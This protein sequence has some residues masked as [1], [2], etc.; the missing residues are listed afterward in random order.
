MKR[1]KRFLSNETGAVTV[2]WVVITA[3]IVGIAIA[4]MVVISSSL[5][6]TSEDI[7]A[8]VIAAGSDTS[9][10]PVTVPQTFFE[11]ID[12]ALFSG[13]VDPFGDA[14]TA[15][16]DAAPAGFVSAGAFDLDTNFPIY[17]SDDGDT[18]S[19][20]GVEIPAGDYTGIVIPY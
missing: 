1:L 9:V 2:D 5:S 4:I 18:L 15:I 12:E 11:L 14:L 17:V 13:S 8:T 7:G 20:G 3:A 19:I 10:Q 16:D 6:S